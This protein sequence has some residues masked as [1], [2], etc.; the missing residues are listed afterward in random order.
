[1]IEL[2]SNQTIVL[3]LL[4]MVL[5]AAILLHT[6]QCYKAAYGGLVITGLQGMSDKMMEDWKAVAIFAIG[7]LIVGILTYIPMVTCLFG[8]L[9]LSAPLP[10]ELI[11]KKL[12]A[13]AKA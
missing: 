8:A 9:Y 6:W 3:Y 2:S 11:H 5:S 10:M 7:M 12:K 4:D 13:R 1:M